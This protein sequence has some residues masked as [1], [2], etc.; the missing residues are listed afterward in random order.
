MS[1]MNSDQHSAAV[2]LG[3]CVGFS[4]VSRGLRGRFR[5]ERSCR[6]GDGV[7]HGAI[8]R[9]LECALCLHANTTGQASQLPD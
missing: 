1:C 8:V 7:R 9:H 2:Q 5:Y 6:R 3:M 4:L